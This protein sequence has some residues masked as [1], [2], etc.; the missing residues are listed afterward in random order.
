M[1]NPQSFSLTDLPD[2][3]YFVQ[4]LS[5]GQTATAKLILQR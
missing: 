3:L 5:T 1:R 4:L 2:G